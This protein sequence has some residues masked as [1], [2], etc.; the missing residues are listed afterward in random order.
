ME[1]VL[2]LI[3]LVKQ[4]I[5]NDNE[6][7]CRQLIERFPL[8]Q[9][10]I[11][12]TNPLLNQF[13]LEAK[14]FS[15]TEMGK[16]I[17]YTWVV[18]YPQEDEHP[19]LSKMFMYNIFSTDTLQFLI[20]CFKSE[21]ENNPLKDY[22]YVDVMIDLIS[23]DSDPIL[24]E[25]CERVDKVFGIQKVGT[26]QQLLTYSE[27]QLN[28]VIYNYLLNIIR[29][30]AKYARKPSWI[31]SIF[32]N[33]P[34]E[35]H[36][37][38]LLNTDTKDDENIDINDIERLVSIA[39][40]KCSLTSDNPQQL[41]E[42]LNSASEDEK[43]Y[44]LKRTTQGLKLEQ[45]ENDENR[46]RILGP[47]NVV[48]FGESGVYE[49]DI[50]SR[51]FSCY[52]NDYHKESDTYENWFTG[53]CLYCDLR[54]KH[55]WNAVRIPVYNNG[56]WNGCY[57]SFKCLR[58]AIDKDFNPNYVSNCSVDYFEEQLKKIGIQDRKFDG[59]KDGEGQEIPTMLKLPE[60]FI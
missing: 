38:Q 6:D 4:S 22:T 55:Y 52:I 50:G 13:L 46:F 49:D 57:C 7:E 20:E 47:L 9:L 36:L 25:T 8:N 29:K 33:I 1:E 27:E 43:L 18:D 11:E 15:S 32:D 12:E 44:F 10:K 2:R 16:T 58:K 17:Y 21:S 14:D 35:S 51:M 48:E 28:D 45:L 53:Y 5:R 54:I 19:F 34:K 24:L 37:I 59:M 39:I 56:G 60:T 26:L 31:N 41:T 3:E 30:R 23:L 40:E 42:W